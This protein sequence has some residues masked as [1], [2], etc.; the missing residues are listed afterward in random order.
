MDIDQKELT[1]R[2]DFTVDLIDRMGT[3]DSVLRAML[4][5]TLSDGKVES[6]DEAGKRGRIRSLMGGRHGTPFEHTALT[7]RSEAPIFVYREW[8]R[9]RVGVSINEQSGRYTEFEPVFYIPPAHRPLVQTG[10]KMAYQFE[11]GNPEDYEWLVTDMKA[12]AL[13]QWMSYVE[14][15]KRGIALEV[16]RMSLGVN[17]YSSMFWTCNLRSLMAFLSLRTRRDPFLMGINTDEET[18]DGEPI[19]VFLKKPGGAMFPS[20]P[21]WEIQQSAEAM[22]QVFEEAFPITYA[23]FNELGRVCP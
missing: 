4:V 6:M 15:I 23:A 22:E 1:F 8:H 20:G 2:S 16:C 21:Q 14:R 5:S 11:Q 18:A 19:Q 10:K 9:H 17:I 13:Q 7:F 12:Q 3:D